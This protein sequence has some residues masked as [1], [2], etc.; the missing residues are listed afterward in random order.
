MYRVTDY[1]HP[2]D[3]YAGQDSLV[4]DEFHSQLKISETLNL[5]DGYPLELRCSYANKIACFTTV[6]IISNLDLYSQCPLIQ[7][8]Q[9]D[10][11]AAFLRR[12]HKVVEFYP[13]GHRAEYSLLDYMYDFKDLDRNV[14]PIYKRQQR[15]ELKQSEIGVEH[16]KTKI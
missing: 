10:T 1:E 9:P 14:K 11:W 4:L 7:Y 5:L 13:D 8:E 3:G 12:I 6:Y 16:D 15:L 2:F